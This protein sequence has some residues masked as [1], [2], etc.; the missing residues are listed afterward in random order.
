MVNYWANIGQISINQVRHSFVWPKLTLIAPICA[1]KIMIDSASQCISDP[2]PQVKSGN[3][4]LFVWRS[5]KLEFNCV[6]YAVGKFT[7]L[8]RIPN[9]THTHRLGLHFADHK[10]HTHPTHTHTLHT[11]TFYLKPNANGDYKYFAN[12]INVRFPERG[13]SLKQ[14]E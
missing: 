13:N 8:R 4:V 14:R 11:H 6:I 1:L 3:I 12:N 10:T 2:L 5:R 7:S 9:P